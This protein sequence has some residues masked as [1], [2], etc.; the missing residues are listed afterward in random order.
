MN[1]IVLV[2]LAAGLVALPAAAQNRTPEWQISAAVLPLPDSM[3]AG[4][5]VLGYR[6]GS[7][8]ELR[9]GRNGMICLTDDPAG[10]GYHASC[11][12][13]SLEPFMARGRALRAAGIT[14]RNA[15]D[16]ARLADIERGA[17]AMPRSPALLV[18]L[19]SDEEPTDS[20]MAA[21][22]ASRALHVIYMPYATDTA[23]GISAM[24]SNERPWLMYSG[25][26]WA[27]VMLP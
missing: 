16:S 25:K 12:H 7:L 23:T 15:V 26:P 5:A 13:H 4:A 11:Y 3:R 19:F 18:S 9:A 2:A 24:P 6:D 27:H 8:V 22:P 17:L 21:P 14:G 20:I 1:R 10:K